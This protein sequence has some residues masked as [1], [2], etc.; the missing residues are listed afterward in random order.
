M[1]SSSSSS[2]LGDEEAKRQ[3][4]GVKVCI[5]NIATDPCEIISC[6]FFQWGWGWG[7][8]HLL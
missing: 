8:G 6:F 4:M 3:I 5:I 2:W 7:G 1:P